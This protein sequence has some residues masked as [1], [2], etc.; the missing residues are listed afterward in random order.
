MYTDACIHL[1]SEGRELISST[2]NRAGSEPQHKTYILS[3]LEWMTAC[4]INCSP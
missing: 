2:A 1:F 4:T 3:Q